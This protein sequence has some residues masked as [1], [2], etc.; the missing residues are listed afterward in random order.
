MCLNT[1]WPWAFLSLKVC[2]VPW[3]WR[4]TFVGC[5]ILIDISLKHKRKLLCQFS[6][7]PWAGAAEIQQLEHPLMVPKKW[8]NTVLP[9][10]HTSHY[11]VSI[12]WTCKAQGLCTGYSLSLECSSHHI[13][14]VSV[15]RHLLIEVFPT[16]LEK[17]LIHPFL[18]L[19]I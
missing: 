18:I 9:V 2:K 7:H 3:S 17:A 5:R 12:P 15:Q 1:K 6:P 19:F 10:R 8:L 11:D 14:Q 13:I 16:T 4:E